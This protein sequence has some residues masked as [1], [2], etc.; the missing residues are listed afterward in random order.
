MAADWFDD[1]G[2]E[3]AI[4]VLDTWPGAVRRPA[5]KGPRM[6]DHLKNS[7]SYALAGELPRE[8][9][10]D[11]RGK[12]R[13]VK[14][15]VNLVAVDGSRFD[16]GKFP[17][18]D[19]LERRPA[20]SEG[21]D[22]NPGIRTGVNRNDTLKPKDNE[23][24]VLYVR[25]KKSF[26]ELLSWYS[27]RSKVIVNPSNS[28]PTELGGTEPPSLPGLS[29]H[30]QLPYQAPL[31]ATPRR[32]MTLEELQRRL[33]ANAET[34]RAGESVALSAEKDRLRA[35]GCADPEIHVKHLA[36]D[37][38]G[39]GFDIRTFW[40]GDERCIEVKSTRGDSPDFFMSENERATLA[41]LGPR[42]WLYRVRLNSE[43]KGE[44]VE[45]IQDP[46]AA[47][48]ADAFEA[49]AWRVER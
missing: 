16:A 42:A 25:D 40:R 29:Q 12:T 7:A 20:G 34:G 41:A 32:G 14:V 4:A 22:G 5:I 18:I 39:A 48:G 44:V 21:Q 10:V 30:E 26:E 6:G 9:T 43:S 37:D 24:L 45:Q 17:E 47:L 28:M 23:L 13:G 38:V 35:A 46:I 31:P 33:D 15:Y 1:W 19:E 36:L 11:R 49:V 8:I 3:R 27:G 2:N